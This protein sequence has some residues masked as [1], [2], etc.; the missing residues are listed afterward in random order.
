MSNILADSI[1]EINEI[2]D[3]LSKEMPTYRQAYSDRTAWIMSCIS[4]LS[5]IKFNELFPGKAKEYFIQ[6]LSD[7]IDDDKKSS[8][9]K[10]IELVDYDPQKEKQKLEENTAF[11][12]MHLVETFDNNGTQAILLENDTSLFLGFRGTEPTSIKDIKSDTKATTIACE[13]GGKIHSGFSEAFN[14]IAIEVQQTLNKE[15]FSKKP[16]FITGHS[17]GG[18]LA[19]IAAKKI[20]HN[21]GIAACY[22]FGSPRAGD[23]DWFTNI[24]T[25]IYRLVNAADPVTMLPPGSETIGLF[26]WGSKFIPYFGK[27]IRGW[28]LSKF[29]GYYHGGNMRYLTNC[30]KQD[31]SQTKLLYSV[32]F[33]FRIKAFIVKKM[34]WKKVLADHSISIYRK[35]LRIIACARQNL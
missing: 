3:L 20:T 25:P 21:G 9:F 12:G 30:T 2:E 1:N 14:Q 11:L 19:T 34:P 29:N 16:L 5:Y 28:L 7:L 10:L 31:Y 6:K 35:K 32:S 22:T 23:I 33:F 24:K 15:Q 8:L 13:S 27:S 18:A 4:E 26:A 17:L